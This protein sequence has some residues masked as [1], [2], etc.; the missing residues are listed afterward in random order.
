[1]REVCYW[2]LKSQIPA[3][4]H[5]RAGPNSQ[6]TMTRIH[7]K[8]CNQ[9]CSSQ[10]KL[11]TKQISIMTSQHLTSKYLLEVKKR[12]MI[13]RLSLVMNRTVV[14]SDSRFHLT[15]CAV[16]VPVTVNHNPLQDCTVPQ[17]IPRPQMIPKMDRKWSSTASDLQSRPQMIPWKLEEWNGFYGTDYKKRLLYSDSSG[18]LYSSYQKSYNMTYGFK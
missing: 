16:E 1:M 14:D 15:T 17:M 18:R 8:W 7:Y 12:N 5:S 9:T 10:S 6:P 11:R 4:Q 3:D 2:Q 13:V